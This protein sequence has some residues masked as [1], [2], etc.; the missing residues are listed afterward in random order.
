MQTLDFAVSAKYLLLTE[1][2]M[3]YIV[4]NNFM[5]IMIFSMPNKFVSEAYKSI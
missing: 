1:N 3:L 2:S 4:V 5:L